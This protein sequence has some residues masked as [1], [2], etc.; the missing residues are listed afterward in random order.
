MAKLVEV[1]GTGFVREDPGNLALSANWLKKA[2]TSGGIS[3][4][5]SLS[6]LIQVDAEGVK[7]R[8]GLL[9]RTLRRAVPSSCA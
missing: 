7:I 1:H 5:K 9:V 3:P 6:P 2:F 4:A 8:T